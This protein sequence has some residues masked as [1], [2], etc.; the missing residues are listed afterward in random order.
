MVDRQAQFAEPEAMGT[1][2]KKM[3]QVGLN[4]NGLL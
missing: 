1:L 3:S 2:F 4:I